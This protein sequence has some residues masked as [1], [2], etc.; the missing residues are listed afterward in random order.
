MSFE[1][2]QS[3]VS[4]LK[5]AAELAMER[6]ELLRGNIDLDSQD[7]ED[8]DS[9][10]NLKTAA[11][12]A[13]ERDEPLFIDK[14]PNENSHPL[15]AAPPV[16]SDLTPEDA[17][18]DSKNAT[19]GSSSGQ[20]GSYSGTI[21]PIV[22]GS[23]SPHFASAATM[24]V[25]GDISKQL[26]SNVS[27]GAYVSEDNSLLHK[28]LYKEMASRGP[29]GPIEKRL[30]FADDIL[31]QLNKREEQRQNDR[32]KVRPF[33][34]FTPA[35]IEKGLTSFSRKINSSSAG[36]VAKVAGKILLGSAA[37]GA[38]LA[39]G[40]AA[41]MVLAPLLFSGGVKAAVSGVV[42]GFQEV[43][44]GFKKNPE[45]GKLEVSSSRND[46]IKLEAAKRSFF[47][48]A[49]SEIEALRKQTGEG[50]F[51][52][53]ELIL[54]ID[55]LAGE[56]EQA[57]RNIIIKEENKVIK[58]ENSRKR[59]RGLLSTA[60]ALGAGYLHGIPMG[61]QDFDHD[62]VKHMVN[63]THH[64][65][66]F[67]YNPHEYAKAAGLAAK[68]GDS[69]HT[70]SALM[71]NMSHSLGGLPPSEAYAGLGAAGGAMM[72]W[73][74]REAMDKSSV[75]SPELMENVQISGS[76]ERNSYGSVDITS[77]G[78]VSQET[79]LRKPELSGD[80]SLSIPEKPERLK[81]FEERI[82]PRLR[83]NPYAKLDH[84]LEI[85]DY[86]KRQK[87]ENVDHAEALASQVGEMNPECRISVCVPVAGHQEG[88][89][90]YSTLE[91]YA[92]QCNADNTP[93][94]PSTYEVVL[95]V[96]HPEDKEP[97]STL[98]EIKRF[99]EDHP[100]VPV[101]VMYEALPRD[102]ANMRF[103]RKSLNDATLAR[104][105]DRS[106]ATE[107]APDLIMVS[108][109][110][111]CIGMSPYYLARLTTQ[112]DEAE[113]RG[114]IL[115]GIGGKLD[116]DPEAYR[117]YPFVHTETRFFQ[118]LN[119]QFRNPRGGPGPAVQSSGGNFSFK[120]SIYAAV[121][122]YR[123]NESKN[124]GEDSDLGRDIKSARTNQHTLAYGG[125]HSL[126]Y[127]DARRS[128]EAF[129]QG[130]SFSDQWSNMAF[131]PDD[132]LRNPKNE[133]D[134]GE[135]ISEILGNTEKLNGFKARIEDMVNRTASSWGM[136]AGD[137]HLQRAL[138]MLGVNYHQE[139]D[140]VVIDSIDNLTHGLKEYSE[141]VGQERFK[142]NTEIRPGGVNLDG[143]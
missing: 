131:S 54:Q 95:Y 94:D 23:H 138:G 85:A 21:P 12:L 70:F 69:L 25:S 106:K 135:N 34:R 33:G 133:V 42:E 65:F 13:T 61:S 31:K 102:N 103:I 67:E 140:R 9:N 82:S 86:Y 107:N 88:K 117:Q 124:V 127:T 49:A 55:Q 40:G 123:L 32:H 78:V 19:A 38:S 113:K 53:N 108:N 119:D 71:G 45:T 121:D 100:T 2:P 120:S 132:E 16:V 73:T 39:T 4:A 91:W 5:T 130:I 134:E 20:S 37:V 139:N 101:K 57:E 43:F 56:L 136:H 99:Q 62:K 14:L 41:G 29:E 50:M 129:R 114:V 28:E 111:D 74:A 47:A 72:M 116:W 110:A 98:E 87:K 118:Y 84:N 18:E 30:E 83:E 81:S 11:E 77:R 3:S 8:E 89:N 48:N 26:E 126:V 35:F 97:D 51:T 17:W 10:G 1:V 22:S 115:D 7:I 80:N 105:Q 36:K 59:L 66:G 64:G 137:Q 75:D 122:G 109:D 63:F 52:H 104:Q 142:Q 92:K 128:V 90:I 79:S 60:A 76:P 58:N 93:I 44:C 125:K 141:T 112:F 15:E 68:S 6:E 24:P 27:R 96:N 46:R 143:W